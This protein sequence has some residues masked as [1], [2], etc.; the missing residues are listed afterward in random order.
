[1]AER[2]CI[3]HKRQ[4]VQH[5]LLWQPLHPSSCLFSLLVVSLKPLSWRK[6]A[7]NYQ[8]FGE[9]IALL[10]FLVMHER[11][12]GFGKNLSYVFKSD[13]IQTRREVGAGE[14]SDAL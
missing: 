8:R 3:A 6:H 5:H 10:K 1:M 7:N 4:Q 14:T 9:V 12:I 11:I 13:H 2:A